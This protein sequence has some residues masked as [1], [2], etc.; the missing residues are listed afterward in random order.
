MTKFVCLSLETSSAS[1]LSPHFEHSLL[2]LRH[3][4]SAQEQHATL[5]ESRTMFPRTLCSKL[6]SIIGALLAWSTSW[7]PHREQ[8]ISSKL[9][10][11]LSSNDR[12]SIVSLGCLCLCANLI[13]PSSHTCKDTL[14]EI[15][16]RLFSLRLCLG[17]TEG[18]T[19]IDPGRCNRRRFLSLIPEC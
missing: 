1:L 15:S 2:H 18:N 13:P 6:P 7:C 16:W 4:L 14:N 12:L 17:D 9:L 8:Q 19:G 5:S 3:N 10:R 11:E